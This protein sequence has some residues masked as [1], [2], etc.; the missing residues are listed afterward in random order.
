MKIKKNDK[1]ITL[2][3]L[4]ITIVILIILSSIAIYSG[5]EIIESSKLTAFTTELKIMQA[6][7]NELYDKKEEININTIGK[8]ISTVQEQADIVFVATEISDTTG[9]KYYDTETIEGLGIEGVEGEFFVN[10]NKRSVISYDGLNYEGDTYYMLSQ[11]PNSLYNVETR[12][13]SEIPTFDVSVERIRKNEFK[14]SAGN[15][16]YN[17]N[18]NNWNLK[19]KKN[20][21]TEFNE[22]EY[23]NIRLYEEGTY[24]IKVVNGEVESE[25]R[26]I[27][28]NEPKVGDYVAYYPTYSDVARTVPI[29]SSKLTYTS[30][31]GNALEHGNG[32]DTQTY[33]A[34]DTKKW[35]IL[36]NDN[37]KM[38]IISTETIKKNE[39]DNDGNYI[40][41]GSIGY[42]YAEQELNEICKIYG[43]GYG[44]NLNTITT[45]NV[46]GP[47]DTNNKRT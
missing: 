18:I 8:A 21:E 9:Y 46:G 4:V 19:Y 43:Y 31:A 20:T 33:V 24:I 47:L 28:I 6:K 26:T 3:A 14:V 41:S 40:L 22:S 1:A 32:Y 38:E 5:K 12:F 39:A 35:R 7:V 34:T 23:L 13:S 2:I 15:I 30:V 29:D 11:L 42:L 10:I 36:Y 45:Y 25:E 44:A 16:G 37:D 27:I 17:G